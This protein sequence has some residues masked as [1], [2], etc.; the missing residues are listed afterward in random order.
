MSL[1]RTL[2]ISGSGLSAERLRADLASANLANAISTRSAEGGPYRRRD[3][4]FETVPAGSEFGAVFDR[5]LTRVAVRQIRVDPRPP[6]EILSPSHPDADERGILRLPNVN[7][8]EELT[9]LRNAQR[10]FEA[11]LAAISIAREM[12]NRALRLGRGG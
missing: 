3:P 6:R 9:N 11:N 1:F 8:V 10:S 7:V 2:A 5:A 4:I 12:A